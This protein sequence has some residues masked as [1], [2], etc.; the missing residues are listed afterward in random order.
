MHDTAFKRFW[1]LAV[2]AALILTVMPVLGVGSYP[3]V[4]YT[5]DSLRLREQPSSTSFTLKS[6]AKDEALVV[7]GQQGAY[8][9]AQYEGEQG[10]VLAAFI[11]ASKGGVAIVPPAALPTVPADLAL[12]YPQLANTMQGAQVKALQGGLIELGFLRGKADAK[13]GPATLAAVTAFQKMNGLT[14]TGIADPLTQQKLFEG[15]PKNAAGTATEVRTLPAIAGLIL[16]P[17]DRGDAI[18]QLQGRLKELGFYKGGI[19]AVYGEGTENAVRA[20]QTA[21]GLKADG[22]AGANTQALLYQDSAA[23]TDAPATATPEAGAT[24]APVFT[25]EP[26]EAAYPY[27]TTASA[28]VNLRKAAS[29]SG[30]RILT[31][32]GG[33]ALQVLATQGSFLKV[34]YRGYTGYAMS[35]YINVPEQYLE[36]KTLPM[37]VTARAHYETLS[38]GATGQK[39]KALQQALAELG[40]YQGAIDGSFGANTLTAVK[41]LQEK[42]KLRAT[43]IVLPELQ[44]LMYEERP[45]SSGGSLVRIAT[46][47]P[48]PGW[49]MEQGDKGDAVLALNRSLTSLGLYQAPLGDLYSRDTTA[50]VK[51]FQKEHSIKQTGKVDSFTLLAINTL[52]DKPTAVP[53]AAPTPVV[54]AAVAT[55]TPAAP[56]QTTLR[57]GSAGEPV[58]ALQSRLITLQYLKGK[59]DGVFGTQTALAVTAFQRRN[60]LE[61]DGLAGAETLTRLYS[62]AAKGNEAVDTGNSPDPD[63]A[64]TL[65]ALKVGDTGSQVKAMQQKLITLKYLTGGADGVFGPK[66]FIALQAFQRN[67]KLSDDGIAGKLTLAK[68]ADP[69]AIAAGGLIVVLPTPTLAP[70][71]TKAPGQDSLK[72]PRAAEVRLA[73]WYDVLRGKI[74]TL[75]N[76]IIYDFMSGAHYNIKV[77]SVGKHADGEPVTKQD[78]QTMETALGFNNWTPRPVWVIFTDG[79]VYMASTHSH[80]HEV[81]HNALNGLTGHICIHFPR[82]MEDAAATGPYAVSHQ[83]AILAGWDLTQSMIK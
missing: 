38:L 59:A 35:G 64:V 19:D 6:I 45:R 44:E 75:P 30:A 71:V 40:F 37:S 15:K 52:L 67:N 4:G 54:T 13:F 41:A 55:P 69:K 76:V 68:L 12:K 26:G 3:F 49:P 29:L 14:Q 2:C 65:S 18:G 70:V 77:F 62:A 66:S 32:P 22:I 72:A 53:T 81:D 43:G 1:L 21:S 28:A 63:S 16:R 78:T 50:A 9:E 61:A 80:G 23:Q 48:V 56:S 82:T 10:Y 60:D 34:T 83:N 25:Q 47:P 36:G 46:L 27:Q 39:V 33:A 42:N 31:I 74:K 7:I 11:S 57:I 24:T 8:F 73:D 17:G 58:V 20:F 5:L 51:V 79:S